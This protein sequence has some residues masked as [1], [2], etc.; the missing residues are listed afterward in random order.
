[1]LPQSSRI[2]RISSPSST[3]SPTTRAYR[4]RSAGSAGSGTAM[5]IGTDIVL[6]KLPPIDS[7]EESVM[8]TTAADR[9]M[10][11]YALAHDEGEAFWLAPAIAKRHG[12]ILGR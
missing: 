6:A 3:A 4:R 11:G 2:S 1:M 10:L 12:V 9:S 5:A 7:S 8:T